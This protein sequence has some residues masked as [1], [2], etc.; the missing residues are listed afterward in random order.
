M[1]DT[2][3]VN[4]LMAVSNP[5]PWVGAPPTVPLVQTPK[6]KEYSINTDLNRLLQLRIHEG[7]V[8]DKFQVR[9]TVKGNEMLAICVLDWQ[10]YIKIHYRLTSNRIPGKKIRTNIE[11][12]LLAPSEILHQFQQT[13]AKV[14]VFPR[15]F[16]QILSFPPTAVC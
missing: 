10:P 6:F 3:N 16:L 9:N 14:S 15:F 1:T 5:Y 4:A 13:S 7:F 12:S 8:L 11:I 2:S